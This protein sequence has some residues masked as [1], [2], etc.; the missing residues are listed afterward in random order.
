MITRKTRSTYTCSCADPA[1]IR[2]IV[3]RACAALNGVQGVAAGG[4]PGVSI[5][6]SRDILYFKT[7]F[8]QFGAYF[9]PPLY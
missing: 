3:D 8:V 4:G 9:L 6:F 5:P 2:G 7:Q 1:A